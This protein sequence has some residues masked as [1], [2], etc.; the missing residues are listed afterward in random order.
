M[1]HAAFRSQPRA[2]LEG[3]HE[4]ETIG[5]L[6]VLHACAAAGSGVWWWRRARWSTEPAPDNPNFLSEDHPLRGPPRRPQRAQPRRGRGA[7]RRPGARD[8]RDVEVTVLRPCWLMGPTYE[9]AVTRYFARGV[10]PTLLGYDPLLQLVHEEDCLRAFEL[11]LLEGRPGVFNVVGRG[12]LPLSTL[13]RTAGKRPLPIPRAAAL[14]PRRLSVPGADRRPARRLLRLPA[15][16]LGGRRRARLGRL[17][18]ARVHDP[19]GLDVLRVVAPHAALPVREPMESQRRRE[20]RTR[21][22]TR[23]RA[24][25]RRPAPRAARCGSARRRP[26]SRERVSAV[27]VFELFE[28]LRRAAGTFGMEERSGEVDE[29][30]LDPVACARARSAARMAL[31]ALVARR[32]RRASTSCRRASPCSSSR[33]TPGCCPTTA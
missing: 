5:S 31:R 18:R 21:S 13:L 17:R 2:D 27:D 20:P 26:R 16:S 12:V 25:P 7:G 32:G 3:D 11:A 24:R 4:F 30:G 10:V 15:L 28:R 33:T 8:T 1:L 9:D 14:P 6:H 23:S 22:A 19:R 29:F